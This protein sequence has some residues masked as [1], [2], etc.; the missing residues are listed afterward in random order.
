MD[1]EDENSEQTRE[2]TQRKR[3]GREKIRIGE[4]DG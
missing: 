2:E 1:L 4:T 3:S